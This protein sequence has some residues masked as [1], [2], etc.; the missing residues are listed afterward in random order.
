MENKRIVLLVP[1]IAMSMLLGSMLS[2]PIPSTTGT[3]Q[4]IGHGGAFEYQHIRN[5]KVIDEWSDSNTLMYAGG[6][7][8]VE[9]LIGGG[10]PAAADYIAIGNGTAPA[11]ASTTLD[12]ENADGVGLD[13]A[14]GTIAKAV[15]GN[16]WNASVNYVFTYTGAGSC[17]VNS[18]ALFNASANGVMFI[19]SDFTDRTMETNDQLNMTAYFWAA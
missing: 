11:A 4:V 7:M 17:V 15:T 9:K 3:A 6:N 14:Q 10:T 19:G 2:T 12:S 13:R 5:G 1:L 8:T 16:I 18:S